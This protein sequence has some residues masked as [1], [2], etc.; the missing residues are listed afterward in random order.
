[1]AW[2]PPTPEEFK[3]RFPGFA[4]VA[5]PTIQAF[6]DE[7]TGD[8]GESWIEKDR[9][10]GVLNLAAHLLATQGGVQEGLGGGVAVTGALKRRRVDDVEVE[11]AGVQSTG[12][13]SSRLAGYRTTAFGQRYLELMARNFPAVRGVF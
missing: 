7:A 12:S 13:T 11:F 2:T 9:T 10:P 8:V 1:M 3:I 6:L 4:S 5:D